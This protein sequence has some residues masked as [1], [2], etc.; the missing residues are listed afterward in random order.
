MDQG[1]LATTSGL[2]TYAS[3]S[4]LLSGVWTFI[5][6]LL[7]E[8]DPKWSLAAGA[9]GALLLIAASDP[10]DPKYKSWRRPVLYFGLFALN[11]VILASAALGV[12]ETADQGLNEA[13]DD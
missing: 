11:T 6:K 13:A 5:N 9:V 12:E 4:G 8:L 10:L 1:K 3:L 2:T 7:K